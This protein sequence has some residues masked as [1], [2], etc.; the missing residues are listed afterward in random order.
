MSCT[1]GLID[2]ESLTEKAKPTVLVRWDPMPDVEGK[3]GVS[4]ETQQEL[5]PRKW[6]T[7]VEGA[8]RIDIN[9]SIVEDNNI[10][11]CEGN[12]VV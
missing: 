6:Y 1:V 2:K 11:E 8:R 3:E 10:E 7:D 5:L 9:V 12:Y 4:N